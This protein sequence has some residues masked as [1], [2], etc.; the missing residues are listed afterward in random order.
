MY[1]IEV[2]VDIRLASAQPSV[3][4]EL[5]PPPLPAAAVAPTTLPPKAAIGAAV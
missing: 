3:L 2:M 4:L 5:F 1:K